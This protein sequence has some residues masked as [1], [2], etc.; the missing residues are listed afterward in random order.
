MK[1]AL[2]RLIQCTWGLPQ[3]LLG[4]IVF[5]TNLRD[6]HYHYHGAVVTE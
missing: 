1:T 6:R 4:L 5:L 2:Y 3:T